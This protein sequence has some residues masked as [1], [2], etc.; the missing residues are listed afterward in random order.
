MSAVVE[1]VL[2]VADP[3]AYMLVGLLALAEAAALLGLVIPGETA[4]LL[5][6]VVVSTGHARLGWMMAAAAAGAVVGDSVGYEL[7]RRFAGP[8]RASRLGRR[9]GERRWARAEEYLRT[10]GGKAVFIG[11]WIGVL[12]ALVPFV[13]GASRMPYRVFLPYNVLGGVLWAGSFVVA[14]YL[15]G[16]SY[17]VVA[18]YAGQASLVLGGLLVVLAV[19]ALAVRWVMG[20]PDRVRSA[21]DRAGDWPPVRWVAL[22]YDRQLA[23]LADRLRPHGAFGLVLSVELAVLVAAGWFFGGVTEDVLARNELIGIDGPVA[24]FFTVHRE[25]WLTTAMAGITWLGSASVLVPTALV[26]AA[27]AGRRRRSRRPLLFLAAVLAGSTVM[28]QLIKVLIARPRPGAGLVEAL[29]YSFPSGHA[30]AA[31]AG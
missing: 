25:A 24:Q 22:R 11:R 19:F 30:T 26:V 20:H 15:A 8:L 3:W 4:V 14:G 1:F 21:L 29:G 9:V 12:R 18:Q 16:H 17:R 31:A 2:G 28:A 5:G 27:V 10:R 23:F 7:G 13:A 6:G